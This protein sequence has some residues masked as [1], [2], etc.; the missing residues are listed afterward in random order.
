MNE[1]LS[2]KMVKLYGKKICIMVWRDFRKQ[3]FQFNSVLQKFLFHH[4]SYFIT[5]EW[6][7]TTKNSF[8]QSSPLLP[9]QV[10]HSM[11]VQLHGHS[12]QVVP[13]IRCGKKCLFEDLEEN[14]KIKHVV[15]IIGEGSRFLSFE[16]K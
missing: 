15:I 8:L 16:A 2:H 13:P 3:T 10:S 11:G 6:T 14:K 9:D 12:R 4:K 5:S 1:P 7:C